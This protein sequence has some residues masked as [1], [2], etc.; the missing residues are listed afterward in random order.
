MKTSKNTPLTP[1]AFLSIDTHFHP[2]MAFD[3]CVEA[4]CQKLTPD[5]WKILRY[6]NTRIMQNALPKLHNALCL[7]GLSHAN[8]LEM[9]EP[10]Q[11]DG[12]LPLAWP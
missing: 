5:Q 10:S 2:G 11:V 6:R 4:H 3:V 9:M 8:E 12:T 7:S 1:R